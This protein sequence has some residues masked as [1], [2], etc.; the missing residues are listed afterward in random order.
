M[1]KTNAARILDGLKI[2]YKLQEYQVDLD[3]L[4]AESVARKVGLPPEQVFKTLVVRGDKNGILLACI[5]GGS[6]LDLKALAAASGNKKADMV[7]LKEVLGITGYVRGGVSP[8]G[9]KKVFPV[10]LDHTVDNWPF[11]AISAGIRGCQLMLAPKAL[12]QAVGGVVCRI[13]RAQDAGSGY[14]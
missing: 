1:K 2:D 14:C 9:A 8:L 12:L 7:P 6:E 13:A 10:Y 5:P 11:I 3:D 4:S